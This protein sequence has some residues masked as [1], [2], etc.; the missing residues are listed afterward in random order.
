MLQIYAKRY[1]QLGLNVT[2]ITPK[3]TEFNFDSNCILKTASH[4]LQQLTT[5]KQSLE[6]LNSLDWQNAVGIGTVT[7]FG[8]KQ[9]VKKGSKIGTITAPLILIDIDGCNDLKIVKLVLGLLDLPLNYQ[10]VIKSGS[11][12]GYHIYVRSYLGGLT[13]RFDKGCAYNP[14]NMYREKFLKLEL[15]WNSHAVLPPSIHMSTFK[16]EFL[17][18]RF[19]NTV[20]EIVDNVTLLAAIGDVCESQPM[21]LGSELFIEFGCPPEKNLVTCDEIESDFIGEFIIIDIETNGLITYENNNRKNPDIIQIS[22]IIVSDTYEML[23]RKTTLIKN[24]QLFENKAMSINNIDISLA[25]H[26]G[27]EKF[28]TLREL[29]SD[30]YSTN[31]IVAHN[32]EFD[33]E[34]I[35]HHL[36]IEGLSNPI[37]NSKIVCTMKLAKEKLKMK[38]FLSLGAL[39]Q[40]L[41]K[42]KSIAPLHNSSIDT[43][44]TYKCL[45]KLLEM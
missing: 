23:K 8:I 21:R 17:N 35:S 7:G 4:D 36:N 18:C 11:G 19:P 22:W 5:K 14:L 26:I 2:S 30:I 37:K 9:T 45:R 16:Y 42:D 43:V 29:S 27:S 12:I 10:W 33:I 24:K 13:K 34:V 38:N 25:N 20:P 1:W 40:E 15:L 32:A 44:L 39:Y 3:I 31:K 41:F 28:D 6:D